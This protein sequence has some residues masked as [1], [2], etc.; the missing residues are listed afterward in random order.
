M[1][2]IDAAGWKS[3]FGGGF[4]VVFLLRL[5]SFDGVAL[6]LR[7]LALLNFCLEEDEGSG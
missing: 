2:L 1:P 5:R 3:A 6:Y 4:V 7:L